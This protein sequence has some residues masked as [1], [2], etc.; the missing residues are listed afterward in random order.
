VRT[1]KKPLE[2]AAYAAPQSDRDWLQSVQTT[3]YTRSME[4]PDYVFR[5]LWG[6]ITDL[7][8]LRSAL[9][10]VARKKGSRSP[11]VDGITIRTVVAEGVD[12]FVA[13]L[14]AE[15]RSDAYRPSPVRRV[16]L[17]KPG[18]PGKF[19]PLGIPTVKD[20]VVQAAM[21]N[22]LEPI[23]EGD[24]A[25]FSFGFR[26]GRSVHGALETIRRLLRPKG[27]GPEKEPRLAYQWA[28][29]GDIKGC[30]DNIDHHGLMERVRRRVGDAKVNRLVVAFLKAGVLSEEQIM[31]TDA[32][33]PQGGILSPLLANIALSAIE[34]RYARHVW[35]RRQQ[36]L[37]TDEASI[38]TRAAR[39]RSHDRASGRVVMTP[40]RYADD[41]IILVSVPNGPDQDERA[42]E[43][44]LKEKAELNAYLKEQL[45][46]ELSEAKTLVTP[47]TNGMRFLGHWVGVRPHQRTG[48]LV[49]L[50]GIPKDRTH[51]LRERIKDLFRNDSTGKPL[52]A[53]LQLL[54]PTVRGWA[55]FY[56]HAFRAYRIFSDIDH[57]TWW[58]IKRWLQKKHDKVS[59]KEIANRYGWRKPG[60]ATLRWRD[61]E[62]TRF[63]MTSVKVGPYMM[64]WQTRPDFAQSTYGEPGA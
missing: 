9:A 20:R 32:R 58:T 14:R 49:S 47:V 46:L 30:F 25:P 18:H 51:L 19:R 10:R 63:E 13:Q 40:V 28:I 33:T 57:Y 48:E 3:L 35:P 21:K 16:N 1:R 62:T 34:E 55:Y 43:A 27:V 45:G 12:S 29:E 54:N 61:G 5:K 42:R 64:G 41:F 44:A 50:I 22:I 59:M 38:Q 26:P 36:P 4:N 8:N 24:F 6:L 53:R 52:E 56:R 7:R 15:L 23:F 60:R 37:A 17:P 39:N 11:G 2:R 31:R